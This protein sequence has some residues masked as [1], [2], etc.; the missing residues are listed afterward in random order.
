MAS[1]SLTAASLAL[2]QDEFK[3]PVRVCRTDAVK[4][5]SQGNA[6]N[7]LPSLEGARESCQVG[8]YDRTDTG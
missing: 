7:I 8:R 2:L 3:R 5:R 4:H 1:L 6:L